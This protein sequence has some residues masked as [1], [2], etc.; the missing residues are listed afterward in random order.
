MSSRYEDL[1]IVV[2]RIFAVYVATDIIA[3]LALYVI[4]MIEQTEAYLLITGALQIALMIAVAFSLWLFAPAIGKLICKNV[5]APEA[6]QRQDSNVA[7]TLIVATGLFI[8]SRLIP[9]L[10]NGEPI[11]LT[12]T[13]VEAVLAALMIFMPHLF[14]RG[15]PVKG[16][17]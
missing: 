13:G 17:Q 6:E 14:V 5:T 4:M 7:P 10:F 9:H 1:T 11:H 12:A 16:S 3:S 8:F 15:L 2:L